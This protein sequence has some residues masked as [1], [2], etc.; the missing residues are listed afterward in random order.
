[1]I[2][3]KKEGYMMNGHLFDY[4]LEDGTLLDMRDWNGE[5]YHAD[6]HTYYPIYKFDEEYEQDIII[7]FDRY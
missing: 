4:L 3:I 2:K 6:G 7:C 1:M 5:V